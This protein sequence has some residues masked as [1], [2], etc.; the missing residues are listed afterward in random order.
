M[1]PMELPHCGQKA[2]LDAADERWVDGTG[3]S[4][5]TAARGNSIQLAVSVPVWRWQ[6]LQEQV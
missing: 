5:R 1:A 3:P 6:N 4:Q 2:R